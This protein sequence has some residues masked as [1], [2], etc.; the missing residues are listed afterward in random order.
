MHDLTEEPFLENIDPGKQR[1]KNEKIECCARW[2]GFAPTPQPVKMMNQD[3]NV[4]T[5]EP[6]A[7]KGY[8]LDLDESQ[9]K[10]K[11]SSRRT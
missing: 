4:M 7:N 5:M 10:R 8:I 3:I 6:L 1:K 2:I 11:V 9:L